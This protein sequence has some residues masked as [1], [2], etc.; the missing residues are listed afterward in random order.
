MSDVC[1]ALVISATVLGLYSLYG[2]T[3][4]KIESCSLDKIQSLLHPDIEFSSFNVTTEDGYILRIFR[5]RHKLLL[6]KELPVIYMQHGLG[7]SAASFLVNERHLAPAYIMLD[8]GH[9]VWLGNSRGNYYSL[10]HEDLE[11]NTPDFWDFSFQNL[12]HDLLPKIELV[13]EE[14]K[15]EKVVFFG[16]SQGC[17]SV[18][19]GLAE[20]LDWISKKLD[21]KISQVYCFAPVVYTVSSKY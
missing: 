15:K 1:I 20:P 18:L 10:G 13:L 5:L 7:A 17:T 21:S 19:A 4:K 3:Y 8:H 11:V 2:M 6:K 14:S 16:H 9:E 12:V